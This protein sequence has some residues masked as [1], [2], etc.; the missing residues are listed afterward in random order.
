MNEPG[1]ETGSTVAA[2]ER[3]NVAFNMDDAVAVTSSIMVDWI[4]NH[5]IPFPDGTRYEGH[6]AGAT[7]RQVFPQITCRAL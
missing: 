2:V 1:T 6:N 5:T 3:F 4:L 7:P